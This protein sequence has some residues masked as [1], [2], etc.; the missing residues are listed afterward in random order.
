VTSTIPSALG[1]AAPPFRTRIVVPA[2]PRRI[3]DDGDH[4]RFHVP[5]GGPRTRR[6][7]EPI[8]LSQCRKILVVKLDFI[9]DY[10]LTIPFLDNLRRNAPHADI[11]L[12]VIDRA[13][14]F[15]AGSPSV[16]RVVSVSSA[17]GRR[18]V[19]SAASIGDAARFRSDYLSGAFDLALVPRWDIDFNGALQVAW[20][21]G[22]T[23]VAGFDEAST[24]RKAFL[25]RGDDRF[26]TDLVRDR[27]SVH[28]VEHKLALL[29]AVGGDVT[30]RDARLT[31]GPKET[32][33][34]R[35]YLDRVFG[36]VRRP[37]LAVAPFLVGGPRQFPPERLAPIVQEV[38]DA[39]GLDVLVVGGKVDAERGATFA[40]A[41]GERAHSSLGLLSPL[42]S[43]AVVAE[44]VALV[45]MDSGPAHLAAAVGTP[46]AVI[47]SFRKGGAA[48]DPLSPDRFRP[49]GPADK[50]L[51]IQPE[52]ATA[53]C[54]DGC[55]AGA[56]HCILAHNDAEIARRL[57]GFVRAFAPK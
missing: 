50:V 40:D 44:C 53:P 49:W 8:R 51:I 38:A 22:A 1:H 21:S 3:T 26:Y 34:G 23:R 24:P 39:L 42:A 6:A 31:I 37:V 18:L 33:E 27:R 55:E 5:K 43:A 52:S 57:I 13:F 46:V 2:G 20:A 54:R 36:T 32:A 16:D 19:F 25:N 28:E 30:A 45:G 7:R 12:V 29:E 56:P 4:A 35:D 14:P 11:T 41:V 48:D 9:G 10:V 15:A 17:E 47:S